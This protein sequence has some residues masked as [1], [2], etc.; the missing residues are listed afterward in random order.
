VHVRRSVAWL[1]LFRLTR[2]VTV[3]LQHADVERF[4]SAVHSVGASEEGLRTL[5]QSAIEPYVGDV[6]AA[7]RNGLTALIRACAHHRVLVVKHVVG[8]RK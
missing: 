3:A 2:C 8:K 7:D 6:N 5:F 4:V 1:I